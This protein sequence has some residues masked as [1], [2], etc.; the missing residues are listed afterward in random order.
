MRGS[1]L[2]YL[3]DPDGHELRFYTIEEHTAYQPDQPMKVDYA[4][5]ILEKARQ[6]SEPD[7]YRRGD[8]RV[9]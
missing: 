1:I 4:G 5:R 7:A 3:H 8:G 9:G 2:P 6:A